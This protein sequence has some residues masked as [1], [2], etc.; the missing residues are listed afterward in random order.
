MDSL[1]KLHE[2]LLHGG[3]RHGQPHRYLSLEDDVEHVAF[4]TIPDDWLFS[5]ELQVL[6]ATADFCD[7]PVLKLSLLEEL[8]AEHERHERAEIVCVS[9][10]LGFAQDVLDDLELMIFVLESR[11]AFG[12]GAR[13][14]CQARQ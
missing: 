3:V 11:F 12:I 5:R 8:D 14:R 1:F 7:L 6:E 9:L 13:K 2:G 4:F 10:I